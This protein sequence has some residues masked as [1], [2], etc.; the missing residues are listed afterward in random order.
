VE[1][2]LG[3][4]LLLCARPQAARSELAL[5][6]V[7]LTRNAPADGE[8]AVAALDRCI[9]AARALDM[10]LLVNQATELRSAL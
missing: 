10:R 4:E 5:A 3:V 2:A 7:L 6:Q 9:T 1:A 8:L